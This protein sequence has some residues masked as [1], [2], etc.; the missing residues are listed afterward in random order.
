MRALARAW[1]DL[2]VEEKP[3]GAALHFRQNVAAERACIDLAEELAVEHGLTLQS[4]KM[5]IEVRANGGDKGSAL[6]A[7]MADQPF[8]DTRPIF[9][10]DD[11]TDEAG[12]S[13]A[14][15]LGG[16]GILVGSRQPTAAR[17]RLPDVPAVLR[18]LDE[19]AK[20]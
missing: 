10:G 14:A 12:F 20:A 8:A 2:L 3:L 16:V 13:A 7:L 9:I 17:Y 19:V 15:S 11:D 5:M 1:R 6:R 4:G 18:W